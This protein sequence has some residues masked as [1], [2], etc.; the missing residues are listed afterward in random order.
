MCQDV[1]LEV[2]VVA[3][4]VDAALVF[5][6]TAPPVARFIVAVGGGGTGQPISAARR[7]WSSSASA[8]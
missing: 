6:R 2:D 4:A 7:G 3:V 1:F 8:M 5:V